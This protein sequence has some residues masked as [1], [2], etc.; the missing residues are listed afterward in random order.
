MAL[1]CISYS[2]CSLWSYYVDAPHVSYAFLMWQWNSKWW[3]PV[4]QQA[5]WWQYDNVRSW[6]S[7]LWTDSMF[8]HKDTHNWIQNGYMTC[9]NKERGGQVAQWYQRLWHHVMPGRQFDP[10]LRL[11][12]NV[13]S[14]IA[15]GYP[16]Y[17]GGW[18]QH[19]LD[20]SGAPWGEPLHHL[21]GWCTAEAWVWLEPSNGSG[22]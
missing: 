22:Q 15:P 11:G 4:L 6:T 16:I 5:T 18:L 2:T 14:C 1:P 9:I 19:P 10:S 3:S 7:Q 17:P 8:M 21:E 12:D 20:S 13:V